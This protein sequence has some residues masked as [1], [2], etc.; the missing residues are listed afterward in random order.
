MS[1]RC[2]CNRRKT[3][4]LFLELFSPLTFSV[5]SLYVIIKLLRFA[6]SASSNIVLYS[7][8]ISAKRINH[9]DPG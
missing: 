2:R 6:E 9:P 7:R 4:R 1:D 5:N 3:C 8:F